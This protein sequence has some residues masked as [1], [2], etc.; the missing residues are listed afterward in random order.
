MTDR[1]SRSAADILLE[2]LGKVPD[3]GTLELLL[4]PEH[5]RRLLNAQGIPDEEIRRQLTRGG[6]APGE[7]LLEVLAREP[8]T[9]VLLGLLGNPTLPARKDPPAPARVERGAL[10][11]AA[12]PMPR[13]KALPALIV[14]LVLAISSGWY[15]FV[16]LDV[17]HVPGLI[18][19][20]PGAYALF[21]SALVVGLLLIWV[22][23]RGLIHGRF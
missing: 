2:L 18:V 19:Y 4:E 5:L 6:R 3:A 8:D 20:F 11:G 12:A 1:A 16:R 13:V 23:L 22:G 10:A 15:L 14:G 17:L 21:F 7:L 9:T